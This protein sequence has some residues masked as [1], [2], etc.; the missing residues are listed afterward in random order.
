MAK[1]KLKI[2]LTRS[3]IGANQ[4]QRGTIRALGFRK[5]NQT[6]EWEDGPQVRGM[7][8]RVRHMVTVEE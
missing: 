3:P 2:T 5:L 8:D 7:I 1:K 4:K 6:V